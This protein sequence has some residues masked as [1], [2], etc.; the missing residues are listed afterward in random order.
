MGL[1]NGI[2]D[3]I[4]AIVVVTF[5]LFDTGKELLWLSSCD[6]CHKDR[7]KSNLLMKQAKQTQQAWST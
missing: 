5:L 3:K 2:I 6:K 1:T 4:T 7:E